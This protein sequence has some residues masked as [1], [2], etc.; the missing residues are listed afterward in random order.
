MEGR[1]HAGK[2]KEVEL[3]QHERRG[4]QAMHISHLEWWVEG[5]PFSYQ[6]GKTRENGAENKEQIAKS[7]K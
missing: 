2:E 7:G 3:Q 6:R 1:M 4:L 5:A